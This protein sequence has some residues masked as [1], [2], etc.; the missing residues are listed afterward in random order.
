M[1]R[2]VLFLACAVFS[3]LPAAAQTPLVQLAPPPPMPGLLGPR[4]VIPAT[5]ACTDLPTASMPDPPL[6]ILAPHAGDDHQ[7]SRAGD[8]VVLNGGTPQGF[9]IGQRYFTRR[10]TL[11]INREPMGELDRGAIRT[12]GWLT[13]IAADERSALAR[14]D[15]ACTAIEAGDY[16]D[17]YADTA[18]PGAV[19]ADGGTDFS[20][21]GRVL[22][23]VDRREQFGAGEL[24]SIDRGSAHGM[25]AGSRIAFYRDRDNGAPLVEIGAGI[26]LEVSANSAKVVL[27]R[28]HQEVRKGDYFG[29]R[30]A[31]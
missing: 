8:V 24:L 22:S 16:L 28:T 31:P 19:A 7:I 21:L 23:G 5:V 4:T 6:R 1:R 26:V 11:P 25:A 17:S 15:Y 13:V 3:G 18:L 10:V 30:R 29:I 12:S 9:A 2:S 14:I 20:N 27:D